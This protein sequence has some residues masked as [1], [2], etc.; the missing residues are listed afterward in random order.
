[1]INRRTTTIL[2][3]AVAAA[4]TRAKR[5]G[6]ALA[7]EAAP[8]HGRAHHAGEGTPAADARS[9]YAAT[10]DPD[11]PI[12]SLSPGQIEQIAAGEGAGYALPAELNGLPG[13]RHVLD[14]AGDLRLT[15][16][17][18]AAVQGIFDEMREAALP[19][20]DRLLSAVMA[21]ESDFRAD[22][23]AEADIAARVGEVYRLEAELATAHLRAHLR[24]AALLSPAQRAEYARLRGYDG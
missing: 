17:H 22:D 5:P 16:D 2:L 15:P 21:L 3:A 11:A 8:G 14:L 24:T 19:A 10:F 4:T 12:R 23:V 6:A 13:P 9:P 7:E 1:M 20:G 18:Q